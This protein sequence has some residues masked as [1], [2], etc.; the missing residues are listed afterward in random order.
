MID[1]NWCERR[2]LN[3]HK[4]NA[5]RNLNPARLPIPPLSHVK[6]IILNNLEFVNRINY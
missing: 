1:I 2:D 4:H 5:H 3:P 6:N